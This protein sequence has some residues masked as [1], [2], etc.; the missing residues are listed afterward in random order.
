MPTTLIVRGISDRHSKARQNGTVAQAKCSGT[1]LKIPTMSPVADVVIAD[2]IRGDG[3]RPSQ[4]M[5]ITNRAPNR[6]TAK[7]ATTR[8]FMI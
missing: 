8:S 7:A 4:L 1:M 5:P 3:I 2:I 6:N